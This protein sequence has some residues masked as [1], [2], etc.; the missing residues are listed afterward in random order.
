MRYVVN[1]VLF[2]SFC[3]ILSGQVA[4][5]SDV[6]TRLQAAMKAMSTLSGDLGQYAQALPLASPDQSSAIELAKTAHLV[7]LYVQ[8]TENSARL[9]KIMETPEQRQRAQ[10]IISR[11]TKLY[12]ANIDVDTEG[13]NGVIAVSSNPSVVS[14]GNQLKAEFRKVKDLLLEIV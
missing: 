1:L 11:S 5:S 12:L 4:D 2:V 9:L 6:A 7:W 3:P 13:V 10:T 8:S 14:A